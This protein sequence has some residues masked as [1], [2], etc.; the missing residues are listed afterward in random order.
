[1]FR[2]AV[3]GHNPKH[4]HDPI[5]FEMNWFARRRNVCVRDGHIALFVWATLP[6]ID[7]TV[8][9]EARQPVPALPAHGFRLSRLLY[10]LSKQ[11]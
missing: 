5:A 10:Q 7:L 9:F 4:L 2:V 1:M 3:C 6:R 11:T 8:A